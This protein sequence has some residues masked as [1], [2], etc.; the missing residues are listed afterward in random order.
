LFAGGKQLVFAIRAIIKNPFFIT[1]NNAVQKKVRFYAYL[2][3]NCILTNVEFCLHQTKDVEPIF[4]LEQLYRWLLSF[5][6]QLIWVPS[7]FPGFDVDLIPLS[8]LK[9]PG[10]LS[11]V[12]LILEHH[13]SLRSK[14]PVLN[15]ENHRWHFLTSRA[16][17]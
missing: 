2:T 11:T 5:R 6:V 4:P 9:A 17:G 10:L 1:G 8:S 14:F 7:F 15:F 16:S 3:G 13:S 12:F